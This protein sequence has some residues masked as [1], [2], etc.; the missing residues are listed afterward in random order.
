MMAKVEGMPL[1]A[2]EQGT[3]WEWETFEQFLDRFEGNIAVNAG[4][5][6]GHCAIRRYVMGPDAIGGEATPEQIAEMRVELGRALDAGALGFSFT[7]AGSHSDGN[8]DPVASRWATPDELIA[9]CEET[10]AH[11][12]TTLEGIVQGCLDTFSDDE[13]E[14]LGRLSAAADRPLN[15]NVL[16]IDAREPDRIPRQ[17]GAGDPRPSSSAAGSSRSP[18]PSAC[19]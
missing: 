19:R 3:D 1:P 8:G 4:F 2:L 11:P 10:G 17:L 7:Q 6:A 14:L 5:L 16:T 15:W 12:G 9:M 13:I 18:C